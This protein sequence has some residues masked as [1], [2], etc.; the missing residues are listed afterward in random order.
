MQIAAL[1]F[2]GLNDLD[3]FIAA[4]ILNRV[5]KRLEADITSPPAEVTSMNGVAIQRQKLLELAR[6]R[7]RHHR[8]RRQDARD[9]GRSRAAVAV[10]LD[11][12]RQ[13]IGAQ[14]SGKLVLARIGLTGD[15]ACTDLHRALGDRSWGGGSGNVATAGG[16][17]SSQYLAAWMIARG[18]SIEHMEAAIHD[19]APVAEK[20]AYVDRV[21]AVVMPF[22]ASPGSPTAATAHSRR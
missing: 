5:K 7:C 1:R 4:A 12:S 2:S 10:K 21:T 14:C 6:C 16:C 18:G 17:L 9:R 15:P 11:P 8:Q 20:P 19:V 13:P 3:S 22:I